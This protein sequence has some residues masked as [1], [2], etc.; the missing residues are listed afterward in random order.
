MQQENWRVRMK[1][2]AQEVWF[3]TVIATCRAAVPGFKTSS[4]INQ[5]TKKTALTHFNIK[6]ADTQSTTETPVLQK[7]LPHTDTLIPTSSLTPGTSVLQ[8]YSNV[9]RVNS[10]D[11]SPP[12]IQCGGNCQSQQLGETLLLAP[13]VNLKEPRNSN[14]CQAGHFTPTSAPASART[15]LQHV[16]GSY[17]SCLRLCWLGCEVLTQVR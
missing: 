8:L 9:N 7:A 11:I 5:A 2:Q 14:L 17:C 15:C 13:G 4:D 16:S 6:S 12:F 3:F 10:E 1:V